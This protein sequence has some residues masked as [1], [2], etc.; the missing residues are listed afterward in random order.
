MLNYNDGA[1][2]FNIDI[3][4]K[5]ASEH[6]YLLPDVASVFET[7]VKNSRHNVTMEN[8]SALILLVAPKALNLKHNRGKQAQKQI[9]CFNKRNIK[10]EREIYA[11]HV[12]L[13]DMK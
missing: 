4:E 1:I 10:E 9:Q 7:Q 11:V 8:G 5:Y 6:E 12:T 3:T 2:K 13:S